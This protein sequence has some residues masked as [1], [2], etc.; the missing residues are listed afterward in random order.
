MTPPSNQAS[1]AGEPF[2]EEDIEKL[3][4]AKD[5]ITKV[6][7]A[8]QQVQ[9]KMRNAAKTETGKSSLQHLVAK[10]Q[11]LQARLQP[12]SFTSLG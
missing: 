8:A 2:P 9:S 10:M 5:S 3:D 7:R 11:S 4:L 6:M 1:A 12:L